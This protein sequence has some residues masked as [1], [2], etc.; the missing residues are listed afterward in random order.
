MLLQFASAMAV[1]LSIQ[2]RSNKETWYGTPN[3]PPFG[4]SPFVAGLP[5]L[6]RENSKGVT[7]DRKIARWMLYAERKFY[8]LPVHCECSPYPTVRSRETKNGGIA[9]PV[10]FIL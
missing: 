1:V 9:A 4:C 10:F 8:S 6:L 3:L 2:D 7:D 5:Y